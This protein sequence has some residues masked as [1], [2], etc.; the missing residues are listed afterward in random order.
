M[1]EDGKAITE[2]ASNFPTRLGL[3][4]MICHPGISASRKARISVCVCVCVGWVES[5]RESSLGGRG[6]MIRK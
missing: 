6:G 2:K 5:L 1:F 4:L 3:I